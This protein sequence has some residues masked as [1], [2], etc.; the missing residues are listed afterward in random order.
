MLAVQA[1]IRCSAFVSARALLSVS[2]GRLGHPIW[3][4]FAADVLCQEM[5]RHFN[6]ARRAFD[7]RCETSLPVW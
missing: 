7:T 1:V 4:T 5:H 6:I 2:K 3:P